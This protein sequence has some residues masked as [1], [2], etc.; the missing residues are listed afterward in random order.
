[1][2]EQGH[3]NVC[4]YFIRTIADKDLLGRNR[5]PA[6]DGG[7]EQVGIGVGIKAQAGCVICEFCLDCRQYLG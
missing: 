7:L 5:M 1:M 4:Q 6:G 3:E 2:L